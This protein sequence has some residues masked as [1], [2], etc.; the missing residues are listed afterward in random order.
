[1]ARILVFQHCDH[2]TPGRLGD[3][4]IAHAHRLD[5]RRPDRDGVDAV[6]RSLDG[7]AGVVSL[8]GPQ[9]VTDGL[10]WLA[11]E[12]D[13]LARAHAGQMPVIG[14]CLGHQLLAK[15]LGGEVAQ[16]EG[17]P[18][19]GFHTVDITVPGQTEPLLA[20]IPWSSMQLCS[21][22][23]EVSKAPPGATVLAS[24]ERCKVQAF[25]AGIA[26]L[27]FQ[28]HFEWTLEMYRASWEADPEFV[29]RAGLSAGDRDAQCD[30]HY[31]RFA[32]ISDR[33][34]ENLTILMF[35]HV[36]RTMWD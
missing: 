30:R 32:E 2:C 11:P 36:G 5:I 15:A 27:G 6:P 16:M 8:G 3:C 26:T 23:Y 4:L 19:L 22:G 34:S 29:E 7:Y 24:S 1:M 13:V 18:E 20:G 10:D 9:N 33:L 12:M 25:R 17:G 28:Y 14:I 31:G 21:H 35:G